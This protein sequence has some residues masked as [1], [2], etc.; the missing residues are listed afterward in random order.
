MSSLAARLQAALGDAYTV[1]RELAGGGMSRVFIAQER[2]LGRSVVVKVLPPEL[3]VGV[4]VDRFRREIQLAATLQHPHIVPLLRTGH[5]DDL[6]WYTMPLVEGESLRS[7]IAREGELPVGEVVHV[8]RDVASALAYAHARG[9]VHRDIKP[10]NVLLTDRY[11][12]VTD[13]GVAKALDQATD[14]VGLTSVGVAL[15]TPT[16]MAPEQA[17]ADPHTDHRADIYALGVIGYE[18][19]AGLPPFTGASSQTVLAAHMTASPVAITQHRTAVPP[20][21]AR[22]IM[23]CLE[24][25]PADRWQS[26]AELVQQLDTMATPGGGVTWATATPAVTEVRELPSSARKIRLVLAAV[27][28]L[29]VVGAAVAISRF[30]RSAPGLASVSRPMLAV[31][32]FKNLGDPADDYF[33]DGI[34]EEITSRLATLGG[35]GVI[36]RTSATQYKDTDKSLRQIADELNV[37]YIVEGTIRWEKRP[38]G[39]SRV[40]VSPQLIKVADDTHLWAQAFDANFTEVFQM[41]S[42]IAGQVARALD[43]TLLAGGAPERTPT[44]NLDAYQHYLR[45]NEYFRRSDTESDVRAAIDSYDRAVALD[46]EFAAAYARASRSHA[47]MYW[48]YFDRS[49]A[50]LQLARTALD[51][52]M[53]LRPDLA[54]AHIAAGYLRYWG[55]GDYAGALRAFDA[56]RGLEPNNAEVIAATGYILRRQGR[57]RE[58]VQRLEDAMS[59]DPRAA[60]RISDLGL[61]YEFMRE[62][63]KAEHSYS[64][65]LSINPDD[66]I[67]IGSLAV[68][69]AVR[70]GRIEDSQRFIAEAIARGGS[71]ISLPFRG[72]VGWARWGGPE[73]QRAI[74]VLPRPGDPIQLADYHLARADLFQAQGDPVSARAQ[75]DSARTG[76]EQLVRERPEDAGFRTWL[77]LVYAELGR[78]EDAVREGRRAV[79]LR[80]LE[81]DALGGTFPMAQLARIYVQVGDHDSAIALLE[82]LLA[83]PSR[84]SV[85]LLR[86]DPDWQPLRSNPRFQRLLERN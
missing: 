31:L 75:M 57:W 18:M 85:Q 17:A 59:L 54:D 63:E 20:E 62:H 6:V 23:R 14:A 36:S 84:I 56:A 48:F 77:G 9:V 2:E 49:K 29:I 47:R 50:R 19:L 8:L 79:E 33:A 51:R 7:K 74:A 12:V 25:K 27:A 60:A 3:A 69:K 21:L 76:V 72:V 1:E 40:R 24:K 53:E 66:A 11:G 42:D 15:G 26:A 71:R 35:L 58:A 39:S 64:R 67:T 34:T 73:Y 46:P 30:D 41:Q 81:R 10:D 82:R 28:V 68:I 38:D 45:G 83:I 86:V 65:A 55:D 16:Y 13:F 43:L 5:A 78:A 80:P 37:D 44:T 32:P 22:A 70:S 4:N 61:T 52:A